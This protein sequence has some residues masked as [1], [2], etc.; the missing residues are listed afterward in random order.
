MDGHYIGRVGQNHVITYIVY[1]TR[2]ANNI[3]YTHTI[4]NWCTMTTYSIKDYVC[5]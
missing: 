3:T 1:D 4:R 5:G 2:L